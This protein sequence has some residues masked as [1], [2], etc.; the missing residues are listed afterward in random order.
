MKIARSILIALVGL[1]TAYVLFMVQPRRLDRADGRVVVTYWEKWSGD[2]AADMYKIV[3]DF[4]NT[5]GRQ[6]RI[7]VQYL[8]MSDVNQKTLVA[9]A[10]GVPP[11]VAGLW[12]T[13]VAQFAEIGALEPLDQLAK[14]HGITARDYKPVLWEGCRYKGHLWSL[15][16]SCGSQALYYN[17]RLFAEKTA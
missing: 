3:E 13:Q 14:Q 16:S 6:K 7:F 8:S 4:N 2:D 9:T 17:K 10:A 11:D 1:V 15:V 5:V 12:N